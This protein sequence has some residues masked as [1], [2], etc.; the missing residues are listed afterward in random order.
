M[1]RMHLTS[2]CASKCGMPYPHDQNETNPTEIRDRHKMGLGEWVGTRC[3]GE[4][5]L[6]YGL[7]DFPSA[8]GP[9]A[10]WIN[11]L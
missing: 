10:Y 1:L 4:E 7:R 6:V 2:T 8:L 5:R 9:P 3:L 11:G